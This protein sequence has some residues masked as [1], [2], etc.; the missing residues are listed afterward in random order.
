MDFQ[1]EKDVEYY[2]YPYEHPFDD[3][4]RIEL[5]GGQ[6]YY[7]YKDHE[8][9]LMIQAPTFYPPEFTDAVIFHDKLVIGSCFCG[10][11]IVDLAGDKTCIGDFRIQNIEIDGY[12]GYFALGRDV[13]YVLGMHHVYAFNSDLHLLWKT[14]GISADGVTFESMTDDTMVVSCNYDP[15]EE[16]FTTEISLKDGKVVK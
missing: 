14:A 3:A 4:W 11:F 16:W 2:V 7:I 8:P 6:F 5:G 1:I 15:M 13:L 10:I 9:F 12:F